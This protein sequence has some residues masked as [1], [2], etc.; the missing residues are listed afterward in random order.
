MPKTKP[1]KVVRAADFVPQR[2]EQ[3]LSGRTRRMKILE[4]LQEEGSARVS[5]LSGAFGVSEATIR[6]DLERLDTEG[7]IVREH[8]GAY[9]KS[10]PQQ[11]AIAVPAPRAEHGPQAEDRTAGRNASRRS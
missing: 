4:W 6:Q 7:Y 1:Q 2:G 3:P 8:G 9:L 5:H 10:V 11:V